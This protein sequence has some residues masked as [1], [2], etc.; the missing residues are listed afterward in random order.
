MFENL[1]LYSHDYW[2]VLLQKK[3]VT[4]ITFWIHP[5]SKSVFDFFFGVNFS[6]G[7]QEIQK[8]LRGWFDSMTMRMMDL[9]IPDIVKRN[10]RPSF[11]KNFRVTGI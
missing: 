5:G 7:T 3:C 1:P 2:L 10:L 4:W 9:F 11:V 6:H 8:K